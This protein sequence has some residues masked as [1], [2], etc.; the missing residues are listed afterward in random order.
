[1]LN[2]SEIIEEI[3]KNDG[4]QE[5]KYLIESKSELEDKIRLAKQ[6]EVELVHVESQIKELMKEYLGE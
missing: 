3:G 1:M 5:I 4:L 2:L 6:A